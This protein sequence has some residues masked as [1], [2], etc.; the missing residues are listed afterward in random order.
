MKHKKIV[1]RRLYIWL[2]FYFQHNYSSLMFYYLPSADSCV[3]NH[4][5]VLKFSLL[6]NMCSIGNLLS[7]RNSYKNLFLF[8]SILYPPSFLVCRDSV[9][10]HPHP[11]AFS[12]I[13]H[14]KDVLG[15]NIHLMGCIGKEGWYWDLII[16]IPS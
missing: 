9:L 5:S 11:F 6:L 16:K 12:I 2:L 15:E 7:S 13:N 3:L 14:S 1:S 4:H 10:V 8:F